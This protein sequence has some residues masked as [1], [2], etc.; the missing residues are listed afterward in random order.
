MTNS[1]QKDEPLNGLH[2]KLKKNKTLMES[3]NKFT[4]YKLSEQAFQM[5]RFRRLP[6]VLHLSL[7]LN[8]SSS[9]ENKFSLEE[10]INLNHFLINST[11]TDAVYR[12]FMVSMYKFTSGE[13]CDSNNLDNV[14]NYEFISFN[15][16][17]YEFSQDLLRLTSLN[18]INS[19]LINKE[20]RV[21]L[22][23]Y[24]KHSTQNESIFN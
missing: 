9:K 7:S 5:I 1:F 23:V 17:W 8:E 21:N 11:E 19:L 18:D 22:L 16:K 4:N 12:L 24:I 20:Y 15:S 13:A 3:L 2:L 14:V 10:N 6:E